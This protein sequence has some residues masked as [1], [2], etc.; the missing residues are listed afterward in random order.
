[1]VKGLLK[2][3]LML[4][5]VL[6]SGLAAGNQILLRN[7][8]PSDGTPEG[9][10]ADNNGH[11]FVVS[12][13][14][15]QSGTRIV[16]LDL[17]GTRLAFFD[18]AG[19][20][21]PAVVTDA[22]GNVVVVSGNAIL[23]LDSQLQGVLL[24]MSL[25]ATISAVAI[26]S[27]GNIYVTGSTSS[28]SFPVT[29]GAY[30]TTPPPA[31]L[32]GVPI[33]YAFLTEIS[34]S[35][36][37]LYSTFFG[38][39]T[40]YCIGGGSCIGQNAATEGVAIAVDQ[41]GAVSIAGNTNA[42]NLPTTSGAF[43]PACNCGSMP[44]YHTQ[45]GFIAKFRP[46]AAEQLEW[47]TYLNAATESL[48]SPDT[49][50]LYSMALDSAGN[51]VVGGTAP[52]GLATTTE[53]L[54]PSSLAPWSSFAIKLNA[55][56]TGEVWGTY[57]SKGSAIEVIA[58]DSQ[59]RVV[60]TGPGYL[61]R[62]SSDGATLVDYYQG[63]IGQCVQGA[64]GQSVA[65][66][67]LGDFAAIGQALWIETSS[68]GPSLLSV[69]NSAS[70]LYAG[71]ITQTELITLYGLGIGPPTP[72]NGQIV[73]G[74]FTGS[75]GGW[76]VLVNGVPAPLLYADPGQI[77]AVVPYLASETPQIVIAT[78][79]GTIDGPTVSE[80]NAAPG[81][82]QNAQAFAAAL[83]QDGSINSLSNPAKSGSVVAI[84]MTGFSLNGE[85]AGQ[86]TPAGVISDTSSIDPV[87][88]GDSKSFE[89]L[90]AGSAPGLVF[91]VMQVNFRLPESLTSG[92][93]DFSVLVSGMGI[94]SRIAVAQ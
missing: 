67:S 11:L 62:L 15:G 93:L 83:N 49:I 51:I 92:E 88:V 16:K 28:P 77:N 23:K 65:I 82:F 38:G 36:S 91:G 50:T 13:L 40:T 63:P 56:G 45:S 53:A 18:G 31:T 42:S 26:G 81:V 76:Q 7:L 69:T 80:T 78:P 32:E 52:P 94:G 57:F 30:Q 8:D 46:S 34:S 74:A 87:W 29:A 73:N 1:M 54:E 79:T 84:F 61:A 55:L 59:D 33:T 2:W 70:G 21:Y 20:N 10:A 75:L 3:A 48:A 58:V 71:A 47:S 85:D 25:P 72:L 27:S 19:L 12:S 37:I 17:N 60:V 86:L 22:Q 35:G 4:S 41:T 43:E 24:S 5:A 68:T 14:P 6:N 39:D 44:P 89:V 90:F 9:L 64:I 66:T